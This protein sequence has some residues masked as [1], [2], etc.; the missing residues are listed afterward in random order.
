[1]DLY[2]NIIT[3]IK[4]MPWGFEFHDE[5]LRKHGIS[6]LEA[7]Q[8]VESY[9]SEYFP[10][11]RHKS[12]DRLMFVGFSH[13]SMCF[14][15]VGVEF[16]PDGREKIFHANKARKYFIDAFNKRKSL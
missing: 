11:S 6:R 15:E 7:L 9:Q 14:L 5:N 3:R 4:L 10:L 1:M 13:T 16:L 2:Y 8:V 12:N